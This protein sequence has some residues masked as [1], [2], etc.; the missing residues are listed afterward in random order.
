[1]IIIKLEGGLGNQMFQYAL[2]RNLSL[3]HK[4]SLKIDSSYLEKANQSQRSLRIN[5]F[6]MELEEA[7]DKEVAS[8]NSPFQKV[9]NKLGLKSK[10]I[11]E[12]SSAFDPNILSQNNGYFIGHWNNEK[13]FKANENTIRND[14]K[15]KRP[16]G[17]ASQEVMKQI[18][19]LPNSTSIHIR[20]GDY[21]SIKKISD[22]HGILPISY[23][24][25]G[26][27]KIDEKFPKTTFF[28]F[29]DDIEWVKENFPKKYPI[30]FVSD[31]IIPDYEELILMSLCKHNII[32]NSTFSWWGA[33]LNSNPKKV[34]I[35]PQKWFT[36]TENDKSDIIPLAWT[37]L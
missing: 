37:K 18:I 30:I 33:W 11:I 34:V 6:V 35:S 20:R 5:N 27:I 36:G 25:N 14:F 26:M 28:V 12:K 2:G 32:A 8:Y 4:T 7:S 15:L 23:Y 19:S 16:L 24:E 10:K 29:S 17:K 9:L 13:Y 31:T 22:K 1:M 3:I 21:V